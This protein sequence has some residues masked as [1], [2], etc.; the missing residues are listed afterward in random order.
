MGGVGITDWNAYGSDMGKHGPSVVVVFRGKKY[1]RYPQATNAS[2]RRY[3]TASDGEFLHRA[4]WTALRGPI[5]PGH[6]VH[7][8]NGDH[9]DNRIS[10][11]EPILGVLHLSEHGKQPER[12]AMS[13]ANVVKFAVPAAVA[14]HRSPEGKAWHSYNARNAKR[15]PKHERVCEICNVGFLS[16]NR[17]RRMCSAACM[18]KAYRIRAR[19]K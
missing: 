4:K 18:A 11:L 7:H 15:I 10:N 14:W 3:Y 6:H 12:A 17:G 16:K 2:M 5:P 1:R 8:K 9:T 19:A 13:R